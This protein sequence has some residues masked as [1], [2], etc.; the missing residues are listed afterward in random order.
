MEGN[1]MNIIT[2]FP[3]RGTQI[4]PQIPNDASRYTLHLLARLDG[5][6]SKDISL[7]GHV[8]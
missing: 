8:R 1:Y 6:G 3:F 7:D 5:V 2:A 4:H